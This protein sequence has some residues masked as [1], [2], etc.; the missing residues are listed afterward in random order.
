MNQISKKTGT[1]DIIK[2]LELF[3]NT[4]VNW[5]FNDVKHMN[6]KRKD[7]PGIENTLTTADTVI[8]SFCSN[9]LSWL[10]FYTGFNQTTLMPKLYTSILQVIKLYCSN[11]WLFKN[12]ILKR[13]ARK[14]ST[15][16]FQLIKLVL[17]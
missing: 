8:R 4:G 11:L 17:F 15:I 12:I 1:D 2:E 6:R 9:T 10:E 16:Q 5:N 13:A 7:F 3:K 14:K